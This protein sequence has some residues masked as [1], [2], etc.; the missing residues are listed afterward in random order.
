MSFVEKYIENPTGK[1]ALIS[2]ITAGLFFVI[3]WLIPLAGYEEGKWYLFLYKDITIAAEDR[4]NIGLVLLEVLLLTLF[5]FYL[6]VAL[7]NYS[8]IR[9]SL[10]GWKELGTAF[11]ITITLAAFVPKIGIT[12]DFT[13]T[14]TDK[15]FNH[16]T[17]SMQSTVF[18]LTLLGI[19]IAS[20]YLKYTQPKE[21]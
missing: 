7:G 1:S 18:W 3:S 14:A 11:V 4:F 13:G 2:T 5:F 19:I 15:G 8:E 12:G 16:F 6:T 10:P 9:D 20:L 17:E 21:E